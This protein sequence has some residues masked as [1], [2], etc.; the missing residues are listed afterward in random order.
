MNRFQPLI[1][2]WV[3]SVASWPYNNDIY[4][5]NSIAEDQLRG[6]EFQDPYKNSEYRVGS[7]NCTRKAE[8]QAL[9]YTT[10]FGVKLP[11][12]IT[13]LALVPE[14]ESQDEAQVSLRD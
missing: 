5:R 3:Y 13:S 7:L 12:T 4:E 8:C 6:K 2:I 9:N 10:C 14:L 1:L 11:Y